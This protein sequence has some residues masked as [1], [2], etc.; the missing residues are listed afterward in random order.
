MEEPGRL[1]SMGLLWVGHSWA[2]SLSFFS[3]FKMVKL[4]SPLEWAVLSDFLTK[5]RV[6]KEGKE[7]LLWRN[8]ANTS[9][10]RWSSLSLPVI[11][12]VEACTSD[13]M[14]WKWDFTSMIFFP[15]MHFSNLTMK[16]KIR[17]IKVPG[18]PTKYLTTIPLM[19]R[20][21]GG[22]DKKKTSLRICHSQKE[23][24]RREN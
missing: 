6:R 23:N 21:W 17:K 19:S 3:Y 13:I 9:S 4:D 7:I 16:K 18:Q 12:P 8:L 14:W 22:G 20:P 24:K 15:Q 11:S 10:T 2:T 1:Q 5:T